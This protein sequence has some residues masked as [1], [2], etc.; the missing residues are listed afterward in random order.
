MKVAGIICEYNP[1]H[2][3]HAKQFRLIREKCGE[4]TAIVC[5]MSGNFVQR[6]EPA[7][8]HR[9][10]R[11]AAAVEGGADLVLELPVTYALR[12]AEGFAA[13][14][15]EILSGLEICDAISFG[16]ETPHGLWETAGLL[17]TPEFAAKLREQ[18]D[19]G[20]SFAAARQRALE[21]LGG[22]GELVARPNNILG[23]EYCKAIQ[24]QGSSLSIL[25]LQRGGDY[26]DCVP[27]TEDPSATSLRAAED[28]LPFVPRETWG[29]YEGKPQYRRAWG[30]RA[31][32]ARL[33]AL[34]ETE[35]AAVPFGNE[36]LWNKVMHA[37]RKGG[38]VEEILAEAK[39]KR[40]T[41]TRLSRLL[42]CA[43]LGISAEQLAEKVPYVR[44]LALNARGGE[45]L[46]RARKDGSIE[47]CNTGAR[48][49]LSSYAGLEARTELLYDLFCEHSGAF[50][51][52][53]ECVYRK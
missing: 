25:P 12:S 28:F 29:C 26:H 49:E 34:D 53:R 1:F 30:E 39:S 36:G 18:L 37:C 41:Y 51:A 5:V 46:R 9:S 42:M 44:V 4:D 17:L 14:G 35:F 23:V 43:Y 38:T 13:G 32:L 2:N 10:V 11:A 20:I 15:V 40:Y 21:A 47:L 24:Q 33:R 8:Y 50:M 27:Q 45:L 16:C 52:Q 3:G 31:M 48:V 19:S 6:G 7:L 22:N